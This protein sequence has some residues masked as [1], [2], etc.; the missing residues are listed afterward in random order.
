MASIIAVI[1]SKDSGK[2][3]ATAYLISR[4]A[5]NGFKVGA[6]KHIH[7]PEFTIDTEGRDTWKHGQAGA[8]V[9]VSIAKKE[10]AI[11]KKTDSTQ[12]DLN[13]IIN[14][15]KDEGMDVILL[16]GFHFLIADRK[17]VVK[18]V[19]AKR[20]GDL[21]RTLDGTAPPIVAVTGL[22]ANQQSKPEL[23]GLEIPIINL[24]TE[25]EKLYQLVKNHIAGKP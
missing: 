23:S 20:V 5:K 17:D 14:L 19:T 6:V 10:I 2:T 13:N 3:I 7:D 16:E 9:V 25:G 18:V 22:I 1:G 8:K 12:L 4:F 24:N 11:L 15:L 21:M